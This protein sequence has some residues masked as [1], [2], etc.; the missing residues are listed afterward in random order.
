MVFPVDAHA[1]LVGVQGGHGQQAFNGLG[2]P[3]GQRLV[4]AQGPGQ[5]GGLGDGASRQGLEGL[6]G[7]LEGDHLGGEQVDGEGHD[8]VAVLQRPRHVAGE[9]A[10]ALGPAA[11]AGLDLGLDGELAGLEDDVH[12]HAPLVA[13]RGDAPKAA[14]AGPALGGRAVRLSTTRRLGPSPS[15]RAFG[16]LPLAPGR[17]RAVS[18]ASVWELG[19]PEF[20]EPFGVPFSMNT[21]ISSSNS[22]SRASNRARASSPIPPDSRSDSKRALSASN[23]ERSDALLTVATAYSAS[24]AM[25][26]AS[27][28]RRSPGG[29]AA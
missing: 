23:S 26:A 5:Q 2:L 4:Q 7:P 10:L 9:R 18:S 22:I 1:G 24:T 25:T 6:R 16:P 20:V 14:P 21:A 11:R 29:M 8:A 12:Q 27:T 15:S 13:V 19:R 28:A 17:A 3:V